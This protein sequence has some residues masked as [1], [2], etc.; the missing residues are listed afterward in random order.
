MF[1]LMGLTNIRTVRDGGRIGAGILEENFGRRE[2]VPHKSQS[3]RFP[4]KLSEGKR[5]RESERSTTCDCD[6]DE[7][8][9]LNFRAVSL[10]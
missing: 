9:G 6:D 2:R 1:T 7:G 3:G 8:G 5:E 10:K 4:P